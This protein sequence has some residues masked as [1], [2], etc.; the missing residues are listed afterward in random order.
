MPLMYGEGENALRS[1]E[2]EID[3]H[4]GKETIAVTR[5]WG[6]TDFARF[7]VGA[8]P[9]HEHWVVTCPLNP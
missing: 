3:K 7:L 5:P 2:E 6:K 8:H 1:L 9:R 4:I